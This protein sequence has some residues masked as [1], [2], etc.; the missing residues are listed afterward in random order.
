MKKRAFILIGGPGS[1]KGTQGKILGAILGFYH[2]SSGD[3][4]R[5]IDRESDI[6]REVVKY[7]DR[8]ELIPDDTTIKL[9]SH[10]IDGVVEKGG[11][12]PEKDVL[13]LDG[14][15]RNL[16]QAKIL[17][18]SI[19]VLGVIHI[20]VGNDDVLFERMRGRALKEDRKDDADPDVIRNRLSVYR[21]TVE[22]MLEFYPNEKFITV[23]GDQGILNVHYDI[24]G[25]VLKALDNA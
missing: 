22:A 20:D 19:D 4:F 7:M 18:E 8:G 15:P 11:I 5:G 10:H 23:N 16:D 14:I 6:G 2:F 21:S 13:I 3:M 12:D 24:T 1:G 9:F 25:E 17:A